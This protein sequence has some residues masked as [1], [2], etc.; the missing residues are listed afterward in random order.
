MYASSTVV[1]ELL[2]LRVLAAA[3]V[4]A[5]GSRYRLCSAAFPVLLLQLVLL[6]ML[7]PDGYPK[8]DV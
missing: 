3:A 7:P 6:T 8:L 4:R 5:S 2:L 1:A